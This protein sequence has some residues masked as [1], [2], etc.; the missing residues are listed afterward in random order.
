MLRIK[1]K[2]RVPLLY[3][4]LLTES[5][6]RILTDTYP[7]KFEVS[8]GLRRSVV[9][10]VCW[11][12]FRRTWL[13]KWCTLMQP[14]SRPLHVE[15]QIANKEEIGKEMSGPESDRSHHCHFT[16]TISDCRLKESAAEMVYN[17]SYIYYTD[18]GPWHDIH[19]QLNP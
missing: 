8:R 19:Y 17:S 2:N 1:W 13:L 4:Y 15:K 9:P 7:L 14:T 3:Q 10:G 11:G 12:G 6:E 5:A 16:A 18:A